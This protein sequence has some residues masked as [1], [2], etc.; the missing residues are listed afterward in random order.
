[1]K[2]CTNCQTECKDEAMFCPNCGKAFNETN[3]NQKNEQ[4]EI[5]KEVS[6]SK[7]RNRLLDTIKKHKIIVLGIFGAAAIIAVIF[8]IY[9]NKK[10][11]INLEDYYTV[12]FTGGNKYGHA[13]ANF[14][15]EALREHVFEI[16]DK[17]DDLSSYFDYTV[18]DW[19]EDN[20][21]TT[22]NKET[23]LKN[24][25]TVK[26]TFQYPKKDKVNGF[27]IKGNTLKKEVSG[28]EDYREIDTD[29]LFAGLEV[30]LEGDSPEILV[31]LENTSTD[32]VLSNVS[33]YIVEEPGTSLHYY[34]NGDVIEIGIS[35]FFR[36]EDYACIYTGEPT[37]TYEIKGQ[38]EFISSIDVLSEAQINE[39]KAEI[40]TLVAE[41][42]KEESS[43]YGNYTPVEMK[44]LAF[45][46]EPSFL[47]NY[48]N[49]FFGC[50]ECTKTDPD[51]NE[52]ETCIFNFYLGDCI[53]ANGSLDFTNSRSFCNMPGI[54]FSSE[55]LQEEY[56]EY[57]AED[58]VQIIR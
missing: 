23:D 56:Q 17:G 42:C 13:Y 28:L 40:D 32:E 25:D 3:I 55:S 22:L 10:Y 34:K 24:G 1:M 2:K 18:A 20:V 15:Y 45:S 11:T 14:D 41:Q 9:R 36:F 5:N 31:D 57:I 58:G 33:Y 48:P 19:V 46:Y 51:T 37:I 6:A 44:T 47:T 54:L 21:E 30:T 38:P 16:S 4:I 12:T 52:T 49:V 29:E 27:K 43:I 8:S 7:D 53:L 35:N 50:Y 26:V 39:V